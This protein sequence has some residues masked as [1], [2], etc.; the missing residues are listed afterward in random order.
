MAKT[1]DIRTYVTLEQT[2]TRRLVREWRK[3]SASLYH[4]ITDACHARQ[5][6]KA[7][8]LVQDL[9]L[10]EIGERNREWIKYLL[11][12]IANY[13][14]G[15]VSKGTPSF[16]GV[17]N[18]D[19]L[20]NQVTDTF[21]LYLE[22]DATRQIQM[23]ALQLIAED[24]QKTRITQK[25]EGPFQYGSTQVDI[26][27]ASSV[28]QALLKA[29]QAIADSDVAGHGKETQTHLTIRYGLLDTHRDDELRQYLAQL[30]PFE[31]SLGKVQ[32][33]AESTHSEGTRPVVV[34]IKES[35]ELQQIHDDISHYADFIDENFPFYQPH[36]T[37]AYVKPEA[38]EKYQ[39]L[40]IQGSFLVDAITISHKTGIQET[41]PF[42]MI[43]KYDPAEARDE[44]GKWWANAEEYY[45]GTSLNVAKKILAAGLK[46]FSRRDKAYATPS[47]DEALVYAWSRGGPEAKKHNRFAVVVIDKAAGA[48]FQPAMHT[49]TSNAIASSRQIPAKFIREVR[50]YDREGNI[51]DT[52]K[53]SDST[54]YFYVVFSLPNEV[55]EKFDPNE[56]RD[57]KGR[58][59]QNAVTESPEKSGLIHPNGTRFEVSST[60]ER[61][62]EAQDQGY[63]RN[64]GQYLGLEIRQPLTQTQ[65]V[66]IAKDWNTHYKMGVTITMGDPYYD[67]TGLADTS[68]GVDKTFSY[69]MKP[70]A[71]V[72]WSQRAYTNWMKIQKFDASESRDKLGR[73]TTTAFTNW[74]KDSKVV[75]EQG[76]PLVVYHGTTTNFEQFLPAGDSRLR[77]ETDWGA[78]NYFSDNLVDIDKNYSE[79][80]GDLL[81]K[82]KYRS[83][84]LQI[85]G[86][87]SE[88]KAVEQA[89][90]ELASN[91]EV[92]PVYLSMQ[93]PFVLGGSKETVLTKDQVSDFVKLLNQEAKS[94]QRTDYIDYISK[95][96][97][98]GKEKTASEIMKLYTPYSIDVTHQDYVV[99]GRELFRKT[100]EKAGFDGVVDHTVSEKFR[101]SQDIPEE[102]THYIVFDPTQIK[103]AIGNSGAFDPKDARITKA[104]IAGRYATPF[105][106]FDRP[107]E[108]KLQLIASLNASR[109]ATWGFTAEADVRG[110][111]QY[112]LSSVLD[113]RTSRFC[114]TVAN[115]RVFDVV[116][117][118]NKVNEVLQVSDPNALRS[119]QPWPKQSKKEI[120]AYQS[121]SNEELKQRGLHIPPFHPRCRTVCKLLS[122]KLEKLPFTSHGLST[123]MATVETFKELGIT[124]TPADVDYWNGHVGVSLVEVLSQMSQEQPVDVVR[125]ALGTKAVEF[126]DEDKITLKAKGSTKDL[127]YNIKTELDPLNDQLSLVLADLTIATGAPSQA[128]SQYV[129]TLF[130][131]L[132]EVGQESTADTL[133]VEVGEEAVEYLQL[134]FLPDSMAWDSIRASAL[135]RL[136]YGDLK[137]LAESLGEQLSIVT[138]LL[139]DRDE[140]SMETLADL[141]LEFQGK[142]LGH[143]LFDGINGQFYLDLTDKTTTD[144]AQ[145]YLRGL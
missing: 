62:T 130:Q 51:V 41:I 54:D 70:D 85:E 87:L 61:H 57:D 46:P 27:E 124:V 20:L 12:S 88:E 84:E 81:T 106:S 68:P 75:D 24:E 37:L 134:G 101:Y 56:S 60:S 22:N 139:Q 58:W 135:D 44:S 136:Q 8:Q 92:I 33:F 133:G 48:L 89:K 32:A 143:W 131:S 127:S 141:V 2:L 140:S 34:F 76:K 53:K 78:G 69:P 111:Q 64:L 126:T 105:V 42:G 112:K 123:Q 49:M 144:Q 122:K 25:R 40:S 116:D 55:V 79:T 99:G 23:E 38:A 3:D 90:K 128:E 113:G 96:L 137:D 59:A 132:L 71:L 110:V 86:G 83:Q 26:P 28:G 35:P 121:M 109:M 73:W 13:G 9:D 107:G 31:I 94:F 80:G 91:P 4:A 145:E 16:V 120:Q 47:L 114:R 142:K 7:R 19:L 30:E 29:R 67:S 10:R 93:H 52:V 97:L 17:G 5:W 74:F 100:L 119:V 21:L 98:D 72:E 103:S 129:R 45:H 108:D 95:H 1:Y 36:I 39:G 15:M 82:V 118:K 43:K 117:A 104:D 65:A 50:I 138:N 18:F 77:P 125:G 14:A 115:N 66:V 63:V 102:T 6:D 11:L